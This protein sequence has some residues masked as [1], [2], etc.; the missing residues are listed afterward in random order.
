M[1]IS[2]LARVG[3]TDLAAADQRHKLTVGEEHSNVTTAIFLTDAE[4]AGLRRELV[5]VE[6]VLQVFDHLH[7]RLGFTAPELHEERWNVARASIVA[8]LSGL[9]D[10]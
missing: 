6:Q 1:K 8:I 5:D 3:P 9:H 4:L 10:E 2:K 7:D